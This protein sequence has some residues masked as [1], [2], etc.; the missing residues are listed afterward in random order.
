MYILYTYMWGEVM[1]DSDTFIFMIQ[2]SGES[3]RDLSSDDLDGRNFFR[4]TVEGWKLDFHGGT[5][6]K[7]YG[8]W[9]KIHENP[10]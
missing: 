7:L 3:C 1:N 2:L 4:K 9:W 6:L 8:L 10:I 5:L